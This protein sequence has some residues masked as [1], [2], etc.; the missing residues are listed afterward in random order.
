MIGECARVLKPGGTLLLVLEDMNP[1]W[2]DLFSMPRRIAAWTLARKL[3]AALR[4]RDWPLQSD[5][6]RIDEDALREWLSAF[7][8]TGRSWADEGRPAYLVLT[9]RRT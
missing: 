1:R 7:V 6:V 3:A 4:L 2:R 8:L 5:H 9:M